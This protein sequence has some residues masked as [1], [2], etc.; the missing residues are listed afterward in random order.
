MTS[1]VHSVRPSLRMISGSSTLPSAPIQKPMSTHRFSKLSIAMRLRAPPPTAARAADDS[2]ALIGL[3]C[4]STGRLV[5]PNAAYRAINAS[6]LELSPVFRSRR[7]FN[8]SATIA[9]CG[10]PGV[11][12]AIYSSSSRYAFL[13]RYGSLPVCAI[14]TAIERLRIRATAAIQ[15]LPCANAAFSTHVYL[16]SA[17]SG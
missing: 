2:L 14:D 9:Y 16:S 8:T 12:L 3:A 5:P 6:V 4:K 7:D 13:T 11:G 17:S 1:S 15:G 10:A